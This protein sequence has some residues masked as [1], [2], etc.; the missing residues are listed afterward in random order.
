MNPDV[1]HDDDDDDDISVQQ[2]DLPP[3]QHTWSSRHTYSLSSDRTYRPNINWGIFHNLTTLA[4]A[5]QIIQML[6]YFFQVYSKPCLSP[7]EKSSFLRNWSTFG[8]E[9]VNGSASAVDR[10]L[11]KNK[12]NAFQTNLFFSIPCLRLAHTVRSKVIYLLNNLNSKDSFTCHVTR[13]FYFSV[14]RQRKSSESRNPISA[15]FRWQNKM[16]IAV[17]YRSCCNWPCSSPDCQGGGKSYRERNPFL[18]KC[19]KIS[20]EKFDPTTRQVCGLSNTSNKVGE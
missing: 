8:L 4:S 7:Y 6:L 2:E 14:S 17:V 20:F 10:I 1:E 13:P 9:T 19:F 15:R 16:P 11:K 3:L 5:I 12:K 18:I